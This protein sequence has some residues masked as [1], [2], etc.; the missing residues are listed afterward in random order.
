MDSENNFI[1]NGLVS[2]EAPLFAT[3]VDQKRWSQ[4]EG[5]TG[6][7]LAQIQPNQTSE[8]HRNAVLSY[9]RSLIVMRVPCQVFPFGS[10]PLKTYLPDGDIDLTAFCEDQHLED[11]LIQDIQRILERE[12]KNEEAQFHVKEVQYIRAK[13]K[14]IK[15]LVENFVVDISFNQISGLGTLCF[16]EEVLFR[17]LD[18]FSKFDWS[19][20]CISLRGPVPIRSLPNMEAEPPRNNCGKLLLTQQFLTACEFN[21][22]VLCSSKELNEKPFVSKY[23]NIVDPLLANNN[24]GGSINKG[25]LS[26]IKSAIALGAKRIQRLLACPEDNVIAEIDL[27]FKNTWERNGKGNWIDKLTCNLH[28]RNKSVTT[29]RVHHGSHSIYQNPSNHSEESKQM[30]GSSDEFAA[31]QTWSLRNNNI[32]TDKMAFDIDHTNTMNNALADGGQRPVSSSYGVHD[33]R[34]FPGF[35]YSSE[36][37]HLCSEPSTHHYYKTR[38]SSEKH[39]PFVQISYEC[40][41]NPENTSSGY[42]CEYGLGVND[43][44]VFP[45]DEAMMTQQE[46]GFS[47]FDEYLPALVNVNSCD[48]SFRPPRVLASG[49][50]HGNSFGVFREDAPSFEYFPGHNM[51]YSHDSAPFPS[52]W[53]PVPRSPYEGEYTAPFHYSVLAPPHSDH[54]TPKDYVVT[55]KQKCGENPPDSRIVNKDVNCRETGSSCKSSPPG[56]ENENWVGQSTIGI[57]HDLRENISTEAINSYCQAPQFGSKL[58]KTVPNSPVPDYTPVLVDPPSSS[59]RT[60]DDQSFQLV[61]VPTMFP[62]Y[63]RPIAATN[64]VGMMHA[65]LGYL[66]PPESSFSSDFAQHVNYAS[67]DAVATSGYFENEGYDIL[68]GNFSSYWLNLQ[69]G[70][71]CKNKKSKEVL[72]PS[73]KLPMNLRAQFAWHRKP[74]Q[75]IMNIMKRVQ[76]P[77]PVMPSGDASPL[78]G[79]MNERVGFWLPRTSDGTGTYFPK[80]NPSSYYQQKFCKKKRLPLSRYIENLKYEK[81]DNHGERDENLHLNS[82]GRFPGCGQAYSKFENSAVFVHFANRDK[83]ISTSD[84]SRKEYKALVSLGIEDTIIG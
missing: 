46:F 84:G 74:Q 22:G 83:K 31:S 45:V 61:A 4:A 1:P 27:F 51:P 33:T 42:Y 19:K 55:T 52:E 80:A 36:F 70:R 49:Y 66:Y 35:Y 63:N 47:Y 60:V 29:S 79:D 7:L 8:A 38:I 82:N 17:F 28:L 26:R 2:S 65:G 78:L 23:M 25:N 34:Y 32:S 57:D 9:L 68:D 5:R 15:C 24:L 76:T 64:D 3:L 67:H 6:E 14:I 72:S 11:S 30:L 20:Y 59:Q 44:N 13:V 10:V 18:F 75:G 56:G 73:S 62:F 16:I 39:Q 53:F 48:V 77:I 43:E 37:G 58:S 12:Q 40:E 41:D 21:Y 71:Y 69:Y 54:H 81:K 50:M